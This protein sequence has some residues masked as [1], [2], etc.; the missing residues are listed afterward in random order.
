MHLP[1]LNQLAALTSAAAALLAALTRLIVI[2]R[3]LQ[4][5]GAV[6]GRP[7]MTLSG[8]SEGRLPRTVTN[9]SNVGC[10]RDIS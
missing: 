4:R 1:L 3:R 2:L 5:S 10:W 8:R 9:L 7:E 6:T